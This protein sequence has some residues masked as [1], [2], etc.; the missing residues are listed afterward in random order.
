LSWGQSRLLILEVYR[1]NLTAKFYRNFEHAI[2][3]ITGGKKHRQVYCGMTQSQ[4]KINT[5]AKT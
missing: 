3:H 2:K 5:E 1:K 4:E